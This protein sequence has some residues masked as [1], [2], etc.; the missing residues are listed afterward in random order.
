MFQR[1]GT[2]SS[3]KKEKEKEK[4]TEKEKKVGAFREIDSF[5]NIVFSLYFWTLP[6]PSPL[7]LF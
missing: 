5:P 3:A 6:S 4:E 1:V 7:S 2:F